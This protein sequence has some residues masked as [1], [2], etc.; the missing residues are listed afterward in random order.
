[1]T[2]RTIKIEQTDDGN[3][4]LKNENM[5]EVVVHLDKKQLDTKDVYDLL[6]YDNEVKY[7]LEGKQRFNDEQISGPKNEKNRLY[8]Y[9]YEYMD[10]LIKKLDDF[11]NE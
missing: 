6:D 3:V 1:M 4:I 2:K 7:Y 9:V 11:Q 5:K 10:G 8:N